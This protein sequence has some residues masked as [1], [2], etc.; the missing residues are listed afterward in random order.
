[1]G[2]GIGSASTRGRRRL[3]LAVG[4]ASLLAA[5]FGI[6]SAS[7]VPS[8]ATPPEETQEEL[9]RP[10]ERT[11]LMRR[12]LDHAQRVLNGL[13]SGRLKPVARSARSLRELSEVA[14]QYDL[15]TDDYR[16][17]S[18]EFRD[19][20]ESLADRAEAGDLDGAA[21]LNVRLTLNCIE[22]HKYVRIRTNPPDAPR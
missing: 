8:S 21:L 7:F 4:A 22:C 16:R 6:A 18:D 13:A 11:L 2:T 9:A 19:L 10:D 12:K 14:A 17:F 15:P 3:G 20:T 5:A 1:M